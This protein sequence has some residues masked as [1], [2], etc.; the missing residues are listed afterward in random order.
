MNDVIA[1]ALKAADAHVDD[2]IHR[3][4]SIPL[5]EI[6]ALLAQADPERDVRTDDGRYLGEIYSYRGYYRLPSVMP[7]DEP[8]TV[9]ALI[10]EIDK[11]LSGEVYTGYK[12]GEYVYNRSHPLFVADYGTCDGTGVIGVNVAGDEHVVLMTGPIDD[13]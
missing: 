6:R 12:G 13:D 8:S 3:S 7:S 5:G 2:T 4:E 1:M 9:G 10:A 11:A